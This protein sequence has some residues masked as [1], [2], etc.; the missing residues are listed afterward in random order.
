[1]KFP[2]RLY[3]ALVFTFTA[4]SLLLPRAHADELP[5][6]S[7]Y[8]MEAPLE[9]RDGS[10]VP[11]ASLHGKP[12][13]VSMFYGSCPHVCPMLIST[14]QQVEKQLTEAERAQLQVAMVSIDPE[15]DTPAQLS[16]VATRHH[17]GDGW[18]FARTTPEKTRS[19]AAVLGIKYKALPDG[20]FNHTSAIILLDSEGREITRSGKLGMTDPE[21]VAAVKKAL[22]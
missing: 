4:L 13:L 17:I 3:L 14:I 19:L 16:E 10:T 15:R 6:D 12:A 8:Q 5:A 18:V 22:Q 9:T 11:F 21:F 7:Y 2:H 20:M 1:M